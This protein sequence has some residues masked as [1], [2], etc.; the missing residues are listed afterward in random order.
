MEAP[1]PL[2]SADVGMVGS[3]PPFSHG[4]NKIKAVIEHSSFHALI[5]CVLDIQRPVFA[6]RSLW[7]N[8][9]A[10]TLELYLSLLPSS[11]EV[12]QCRI[13][14]ISAQEKKLEDIQQHST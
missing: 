3:T 13:I 8:H 1:G 11:C 6:N 4:S 10:Y 2:A 7:S 12:R 9:P 5:V 14:F